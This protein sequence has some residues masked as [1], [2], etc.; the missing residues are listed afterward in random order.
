MNFGVYELSYAPFTMRNCGEYAMKT[1][2]T[3]EEAVAYLL[4]IPKFTKKNTMGDTKTFLKIFNLPLQHKKIVH[5]AGTNGKG[6]VCC[7]LNNILN[8][9]GKTTGLFT[10][11][12]LVDIRERFKING[13]MVS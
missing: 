2:K 10:S 9:A 5:V 11:P 1:I 13:E 4:D 7:Y 3:Y 12:H 8:C 6:S